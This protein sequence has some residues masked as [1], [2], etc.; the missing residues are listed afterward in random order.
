MAWWAAAVCLLPCGLAL[1]SARP[2]G[3]WLRSFAQGFCHQDPD[4]CYWLGGLPLGLCVRCFCI[5]LGLAAGHLWFAGVR[6]SER[7][8]IRLAFGAAFLMVADVT[9]EAFGAYHNLK[10]LRATTGFGFGFSGAALTL[11]GLVQLLSPS[12][13]QQKKLVVYEPQ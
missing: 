13:P 6:C 11:R 8:A 9:A 10:W 5:Y 12:N 4:R 1:A 3:E 7:W 2:G